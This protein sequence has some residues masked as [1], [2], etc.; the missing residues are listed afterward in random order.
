MLKFLA[1]N[2]YTI[3]RHAVLWAST[4]S[5]KSSCYFTEPITLCLAIYQAY[6][7]QLLIFDKIDNLAC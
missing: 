4:L 2:G 1:K 5:F 7:Y 3:D 6:L